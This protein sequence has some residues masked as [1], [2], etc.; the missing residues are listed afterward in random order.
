MEKISFDDEIIEES[1]EYYGE[2]MQKVVCMEECAE[3]AQAVAKAIRYPENIISRAHLAEEMADVAICL[4]MLQEM[5]GID[6]EELQTWIRHKQERVKE[7]M[8][9][10]KWEEH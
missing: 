4:R 6:E 8:R 2:S 5:C 9:E 3:L 7:R 10:G 1:I